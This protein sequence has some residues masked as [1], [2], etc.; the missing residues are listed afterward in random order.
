MTSLV[1]LLL[2][3]LLMPSSV[4]SYIYWYYG[5][6]QTVTP[7]GAGGTYEVE[8]RNKQATYY[9]NVNP[10]RCAYGNCGATIQ[11]IST[12]TTYGSYRIRWCQKETKTRLRLNSN[13]PFEIRYPT[14]SR[15][16]RLGYWIRDYKN[17]YVPWR[18]MVHVDLGIRSDTKQS[19]RP[20]VSTMLPIVRV[21][22]NCPRTF[23]LN[24]FD[25][26][27]DRVSCRVAT[28]SSNYECGRCGN[29]PGLSLDQ[30]SC[31]VTYTYAG[32]RGHIPIEL[33]VEDFPKK[34]IL[35]AYSDG[36]YT[37][38]QPLSL[39]RAKRQSAF[40]PT[41]S[42]TEGTTFNPWIDD[43]SSSVSTEEPT[44]SRPTTST[45]ETT[46]FIPRRD[47]FISSVP[48]EEPT[49]TT[50]V[51]TT[52]NELPE[53]VQAAFEADTNREFINDMFINPQNYR[54]SIRPLSKIPLQFS[55]YVDSHSAP[56]CTEGHY[57]PLFSPPTPAN[58]VHLP[59]FVNTTLEIRIKAIALYTS[60]YKVLVTGPSGISS[61]KIATGEF[62]IRWT[63]TD[64]E[65]HDHFP[66][67]FLAEGLDRYRRV[68]HSE[69]RCV[70]VDVGHY[71][72]IVTCNETTM[73]V[74][75]EKTYL[76][77]SYEDSLHLRSSYTSSEC[78]L[79]TLS[80]STHLVAVMSLDSCG[81]Y[82]EED[83]DNI[84]YKNGITS[85]E[86]N[87]TIS[88]KADVEIAFCCAFP[89]KNNLTLGFKHKN[90]YAFK[91]RGFGSFSFQFEF[92]QS[93]LFRQ[94]VDAST[95]PVEVNLNQMMF[96][97]IEATSSMPDVELFVE[98]C[99]A[100]PEDNP[101]SRISYSIIE[102]GC[103]KDSTVQVYPSSTSQFRF[104]MAAFEFIGANN[105]VYITCSVLLCE[106][107]IPN[108]RCSQGC[109]QPGSHRGRREAA[110]QTS[111]HLISQGPLHLTRSLD[112]PN[113]RSA[114][115][116]NLSQVLNVVLVASCLLFVGVVVYR[117]RRSKTKYQ[118]LPTSDYE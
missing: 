115:F 23:N 35:L 74:E 85:A 59:A 111:R 45:T 61:R 70:T 64:Y 13:L 84:L 26:D 106:T 17:S 73:M 31:S 47:D 42:T 79:K 71:E 19:N 78:S 2:L 107:S 76:L 67:C 15:Y 105:E 94:Q 32:R 25:P 118:P 62:V 52:V 90:P 44:T 29:Q 20:P 63:P 91:E 50:D 87:K 34:N 117:S 54:S 53:A 116:L 103:V 14:S 33:V 48:T 21:T 110:S 97:Q 55:V 1:L 114:P 75:V 93:Q 49:T 68:Y 82:V 6:A 7:K 100:T 38:K 10:Y 69:L 102:N 18:M 40:R 46:T 101:N 60:I 99:K 22:R 8:L 77:R 86:P 113:G 83:Q 108:T 112:S 66:V 65:L 98:S 92:F 81:T 88:R 11:S 43:S 37:L 12:M 24:M 56:S 36:S 95:Y 27:G 41:A 4:W 58:G 80:N 96:M 51:Q 28:N 3:V 109:I 89:K 57:F 9:C 104:G 39:R 5:G 16:H 72:A 30:D